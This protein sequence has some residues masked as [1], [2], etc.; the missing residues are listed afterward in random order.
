MTAPTFTV[1]G[2]GGYNTAEDPKIANALQQ[3]YDILNGNIDSSNIANNSVAANDLV[4]ALA[5]QLGLANALTTGRGKFALATEEARTGTKT[6]YDWMPTPDRVQNITLPTDGLIFVMYQAL[7]KETVINAAN[8]AIFVG[9]NQLAMPVPNGAPSTSNAQGWLQAST[10]TNLYG[11]LS[12]Y[13]GGLAPPVWGTY[14]TNYGGN[15]TEVTTGE[16]VGTL[17][18]PTTAF[19]GGVCS[20]FAAAGTYDI[21][22]K[23]KASSGDV[24]AKNRHLWVWTMGF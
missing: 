13:A 6:S 24:Y 10:G 17:Y 15:S 22:I 8:A 20:I 21:G 9:A 14:G 11:L 1:P 16:A 19:A 5:Q 4:T 12:T 3:I 23:F 18:G 7:W 2:L